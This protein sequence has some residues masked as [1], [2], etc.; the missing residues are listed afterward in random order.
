MPES[1]GDSGIDWGDS[2]SPVASTPTPHAETLEGLLAIREQELQRLLAIREQGLREKVANSITGKA[3]IWGNVVALVV[4]VVLV[5][6]DQLNISSGLIKPSERVFTSQVF[7]ALLGA[8]TV[9]VGSTVI[10]I[11]RHLFPN[12]LSESRQPPV[13][14]VSNRREA[15]SRRSEL[16]PLVRLVAPNYNNRSATMAPA[17]SIRPAPTMRRY[18]SSVKC[19][20]GVYQP[21]SASTSRILLRSRFELDINAIVTSSGG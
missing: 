11:A 21:R 19:W 17:R 6:L 2:A 10:I 8:T 3:F 15:Q 9:Q 20:C 13:A 18:S 12:R 14:R 7:M 4:L 1:G 5:I 16:S